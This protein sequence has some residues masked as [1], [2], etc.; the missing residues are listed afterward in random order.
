MRPIFSG[1][2]AEFIADPTPEI[3]FEGARFSGKTWAALVKIIQ[4]CLDH[5]G[6]EWLICRYS[7]TEVENTLQPEFERMLNRFG[8]TAPW[9][10]RQRAYIFPAKAGKISKVFAFGL[11]AQTITQ[12]LSKVRGLSVGG[13]WL[14]QA[15]ETPRKIL[16][17]LPFATRQPDYPHQ[18]IYTPNPTTKDHF[19]V[20]RFPDDNHIPHRKHY[21]VSLYNNPHV[22]KDKLK[23]L[24]ADFPPTH[25]RYKS[26]VMGMRGV[27]VVGIP[28]YDRVFDR[29]THVTD[30]RWNDERPVLEAI[31]FGQHHPAWV[32]VQRNYFGGMDILSAVMGKFLFLDTFLPLVQQ[33]REAWFPAAR[34]KTYCDAPPETGMARFTNI[35]TLRLSGLEPHWAPNSSAAD[36]RE[37]VIQG[38]SADLRKR[39]KYGIRLNADHSRFRVISTENLK[40]DRLGVQDDFLLDGLESAYVWD[41]HAISVG[42]KKVRQP[43]ADEWTDSAQRCLENLWLNAFAGRQSDADIETKK[44]TSAIPEYRPPSV[45]C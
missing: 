22:P 24:E 40:T 32:A 45:Y 26:L 10:E 44:N 39:G 21:R 43:K 11:K 27:N 9:D 18:V 30:L 28:V 12:E 3:C 14:E 19:L 23:E 34:F 17:E 33:C 29:D 1:I 37:A 31:Q 4:S 2:H 35:N 36:Q 38:I 6:I 8:I 15:E 7:G 16:E 41:D 20:D 42:S 25:A 5:T 13:I